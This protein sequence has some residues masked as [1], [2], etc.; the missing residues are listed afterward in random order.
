MIIKENVMGKAFMLDKDNKVI[1]VVYH[2]YGYEGDIEE[3]TSCVYFLYKYS[4]SYKNKL[5][6]MLL[7]YISYCF[8]ESEMSV[9]KIKTGTNEFKRF[10]DYVFEEFSMDSIAA[11][12]FNADVY[13]DLLNIVNN[14][15]SDTVELMGIYHGEDNVEAYI[16]LNENYVRV[17]VGGRYDDNKEDCVYFRISSVNYDWGDNIIDVVF[18][19]FMNVGYITIERDMESAKLSK[20]SHKIYKTKDGQE[21][22][23]MPIKDFV[24]Q[25]HIPLVASYKN[26]SALLTLFEND[27]LFEARKFMPKAILLAT[28]K[29]II[30][31]QISSMK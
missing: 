10:F 11:W 12:S 1:D 13:N 26:D 18:N 5:I 21:I 2:P 17:R 15:V 31:E 27:R 20:K 24:Y 4:T 19:K 28:Y 23:H 3:N 8:N 30:K 14:N 29:Q 6:Q 22:N 25:E 9:P 16:C 7:N